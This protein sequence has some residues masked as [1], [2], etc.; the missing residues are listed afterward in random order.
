MSSHLFTLALA[1]AGLLR[2]AVEACGGGRMYGVRGVN[3]VVWE[4]WCERCEWC[5]N[6][7]FTPSIHTPL[8]TGV[9]VGQCATESA[10]QQR[11]LRC[12]EV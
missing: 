6:E 12:E 1:R 5:V 2:D 9:L 10:A 8:R 11:R 3:G 4:V 7:L